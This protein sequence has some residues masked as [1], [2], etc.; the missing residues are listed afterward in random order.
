M[1]A[2]CVSLSFTLFCYFG[3]HLTL[4]DLFQRFLVATIHNI[5]TY[6][7]WVLCSPYSYSAN[8]LLQLSFSGPDLFGGKRFS[9]FQSFK[10]SFKESIN[11]SIKKDNSK[12]KCDI[13]RHFFH[14]ILD[15]C[16]YGSCSFS[17]GTRVLGSWADSFHFLQNPKK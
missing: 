10:E 4:N 5:L 14:S 8:P 16:I 6:A 7:L 11:L 2:S 12:R 3:I 1:I 15:R 9:K 17:L 13:T